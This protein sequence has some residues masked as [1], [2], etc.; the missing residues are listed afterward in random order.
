MAGGAGVEYILRYSLPDNDLVAENFRSR[1]KS[2]EYG[3]LAIDFLPF[4]RDPVL[5][6]EERRRAGRQREA[7]QQPVLLA[8]ANEVYLVYL[9]TGG[10]RMLD[11]SKASGR[12]HR[13][14]GSIHATAAR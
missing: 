8:K 5:G 11:L 7:R 12:I 1:D 13:R 14:R 10:T 9:T 6:D 4:I 2:W 3:R